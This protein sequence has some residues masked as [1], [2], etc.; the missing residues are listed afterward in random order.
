M[1]TRTFVL[2]LA[3]AM[4][5]VCAC[6]K[7][8][9]APSPS[10]DLENGTWVLSKAYIDTLGNGTFNT[11]A[12]FTDTSY[13]HEFFQFGANGILTNTYYH[14]VV[15]DRWALIDN[16][17]Y[18]Q[19]TDTSGGATTV[20]ND[21]VVSLTS[22]NMELKDTTGVAAGTGTTTWTFFVKQGL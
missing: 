19:V 22:S 9:P 18:L 13:S 1:K 11:A 16:N 7:N 14:L 6:K 4:L 15:T 20:T 2:V 17:T 10:S 5:A 8:S 21:Y 3:G 12:V